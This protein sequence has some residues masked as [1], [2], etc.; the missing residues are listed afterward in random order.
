M[1]KRSK[2]GNKEKRL[3]KAINELEKALVIDFTDP[4]IWYYIGKVYY[5]L[6]SFHTY[7]KNY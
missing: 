5:C 4:Q 3:L 2:Y 1:L 7:L 6:T